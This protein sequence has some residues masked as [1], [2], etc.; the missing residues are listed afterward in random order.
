MQSDTGDRLNLDV[1][2]LLLAVILSYRKAYVE[3]LEEFVC[4]PSLFWLH[5][6]FFISFFVAFFI[7]TIPFIN[8]YIYVAEAKFFPRK[9]WE[10]GR[11]CVTPSL[12]PSVYGLKIQGGLLFVTTVNIEF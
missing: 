11:G 8:S 10:R 5:T 2:F 12:P 3:E 9:Y 7:Y 4:G 6:L 1:L